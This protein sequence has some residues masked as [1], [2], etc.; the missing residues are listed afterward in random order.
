M[1]SPSAKSKAAPAV[2]NDKTFVIGQRNLGEPNTTWWLNT[3]DFYA[4]ARVRAPFMRQSR[5]SRIDSTTIGSER[6]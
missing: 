2:L 1:A 5:F 4:N 6:E 3:R